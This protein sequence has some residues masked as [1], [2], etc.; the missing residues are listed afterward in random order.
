MA[1]RKD[2]YPDGRQNQINFTKKWVSVFAEP[3]GQ[4]EKGRKAPENWQTW[5]IPDDVYNDFVKKQRAAEESLNAVVLSGLRE[6]PLHKAAQETF[7]GLDAASRNIKRR[8][9]FVPPLTVMN[10][11][12]LGI[13]ERETSRWPKPEPRHTVT[14]HISN[15]DLHIIQLD[16]IPGNFGDEDISDFSYSIR[17][18]ILSPDGAIPEKSPNAAYYMTKVPSIPEDLPRQFT[19][20]RRREFFRLSAAEA[21]KIAYFCICYQ[22]AKGETGPWSPMITAV[23]T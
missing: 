19:R 10:I 1:K 7:A 6:G 17:V 8:W 14:A 2:W 21:G 23:I 22:N 18:G 16:I 15:P 11:A 5:G 3:S 20:R 13:K 12:A 4:A 9:L